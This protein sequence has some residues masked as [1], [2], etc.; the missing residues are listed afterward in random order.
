[1]CSAEW[2]HSA[3]HGGPG[4]PPGGG[5]V[6]AG[7]RREPEHRHRGERTSLAAQP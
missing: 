1:M 4:E 6:P 7:A 5:A 2:L 3:L